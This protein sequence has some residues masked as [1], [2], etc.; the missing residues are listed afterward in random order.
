[1][2]GGGFSFGVLLIAGAAIVASRMVP[3]PPEPLPQPPSAQ[4]LAIGL[5]PAP[6]GNGLSEVTLARSPDGHFY[7]DARING[8]DVRLLVDTGASG[9]VLTRS[10]AMRAGIGT[11]NATAIGIGAGGKVAL[12]PV[13][14]ARLTI[15]P[16]AA[17][18][19]PAMVADDSAL[20]ISLL[21]Q[22]VL[23]RLG[24]IRI[25]GERMVLR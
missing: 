6:I 18:S 1:M 25:E 19:L 15:G 23:S 22:S 13:T 9:L 3:A 5:T 7:V 14:V 24:S 17:D 11:G 2:A 10:D 4:P 16:I 21:G 8:A 20:P 12:Q